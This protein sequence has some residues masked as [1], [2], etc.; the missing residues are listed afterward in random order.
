[1]KCTSRTP[2]LSNAVFFADT[3]PPDPHNLCEAWMKLGG[4]R[5][6]HALK[7]SQVPGQNQRWPRGRINLRIYSARLASLAAWINFL[8]TECLRGYGGSGNVRNKPDAHCKHTQGKS[9]VRQSTC[10]APLAGQRRLRPARAGTQRPPSQPLGLRC[11][12]QEAI[13]ARTRFA[14]ILKHLKHV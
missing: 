3:G 12:H 1:M 10:S 9:S 14:A 4:R 13:S 7:Q 5:G 11:Q 8:A 2:C 6:S